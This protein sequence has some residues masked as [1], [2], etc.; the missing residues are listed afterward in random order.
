[1]TPHA[2]QA[3]NQSYA[4][5][6]TNLHTHILTHLYTLTIHTMCFLYSGDHQSAHSYTYVLLHSNHPYNVFLGTT[7]M[8]T[9]TL[10]HIHTFRCTV[11]H[12]NHP[13]VNP[14][15]CVLW[16]LGTTNLHTDT[17]TYLLT[18]NLSVSDTALTNHPYTHPLYMFFVP[19]ALSKCT[20]YT[21]W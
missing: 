15:W 7:N 20:L 17:L 18:Y 5:G 10:I 12:S 9:Y 4:L 8:H 11:I 13:Y 19:W 21:S 2:A 6:T 3:A 16:T 1:M 14:L